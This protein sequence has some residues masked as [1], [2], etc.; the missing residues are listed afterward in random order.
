MA[1]Q[2]LHVALALCLVLAGCSLLGPSPTRE[3]RAVSALD[4]ATT[5]V[6]AADTYRFASDLRVVATQGDRTETVTASLTGA[7]AVDAHRMRANAT[8]DGETRRSYLA[9]WTRYQ[10]CGPPWDGWARED[11][12]TEDEWATQSPLTRQLSL[13]ESGSLYWNDTRALDGEA[14]VLVTGEPT[15]KALGQYQDRRRGSLLGGPSVDDV[16]LRVWLD[17][18]TWRPVK[19]ELRFD[20]NQGDASA[21]ARMVTTFAGYGDDVSIEVPAAAKADPYELGCPGE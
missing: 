4:N 5:A 19:T 6:E 8:R 7:V 3:D 17:A 2:A 14:V 9:N 15:G 21:G 1:R 11:L 12:D 20:V 13:L 18:E 10:E 16:S